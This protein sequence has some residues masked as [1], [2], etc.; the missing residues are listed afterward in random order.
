MF[1]GRR[2]IGLRSRGL[3]KSLLRFRKRFRIEAPRRRGLCLAGDERR[4]N[5][6]L[7][8]KQIEAVIQLTQTF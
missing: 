7:V 4:R 5:K 6:R 2:D 8:I 1:D 3:R